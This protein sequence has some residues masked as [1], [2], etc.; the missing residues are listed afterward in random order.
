MARRNQPSSIDQLPPAL[1]DAL[2]KL[3]TQHNWTVDQLVEW[4]K[5]Q[6]HEKSRS[7]VGRH[8]RN[9]HLDVEAAAEKINRAQSISTAL[10]EKFG[11]KPDNELA[12]LNIQ[13]MQGQIFDML[14]AE[15]ELDEEGEASGTDPLTVMRLSKTIQNL[16]SAEKM[17]AERVK[18]ITDDARKEEQ[19]RIKAAMADGVERGELDATAME[20]ARRAMGFD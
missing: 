3:R 8:V 14:L 16:L 15:G 7:A 17:N 6:G 2:D 4:L 12:R 20:K 13:M 9:L 10:V 1:R 11:D 5:E 18:Q 19:E